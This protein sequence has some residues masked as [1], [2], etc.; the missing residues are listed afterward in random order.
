MTS[1]PY[2]PAAQFDVETTDLL[3]LEHE[4]ISLEATIYQP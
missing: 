1:V 2:N 4:S 3:Y